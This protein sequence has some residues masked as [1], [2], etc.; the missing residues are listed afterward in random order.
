ME[1]G[2]KK[3][4]AVVTGVAGFI[5]SR[6]A[7]RL[8]SEGFVVVGVD[9]LSG[10]AISNIPDGVEFIVGDLTCGATISKLPRSPKVIMH[11]AGQSS[12]EISFDDPSSD[13]RKNVVST[14][15][16]IRYGLDEHV[17]KFIYAS[18]MSVYGD[19]HSGRVA[20][21]SVSVPISC[22]GVGKLASENYLR[23]YSSRL[24]FVCLRMFN[25]YGP[26]Q[27]LAN[28]RQGMVSIFVAQALESGHIQVKG[29]LDRFRDFVF[30]DDVVDAWV[31]GAFCPGVKNEIINVG[32]GIK[33]SVSELLS[34][35]NLFIP[36]MSYEVV[37]ETPGDQFGIYADMTKA[38]SLLNFSAHTR[39]SVGLEKFIASIDFG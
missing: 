4:I 1:L 23:I 21:N 17:E 31:R 29:S 16:L 19:Q 8:L 39:L 10:G 28:L 3:D 38:Q 11:L 20:E 5:G 30:I 12:G 37:C 27:D 7:E 33:T 26:G 15:N 18:S 13:L 34:A 6:L 32:T 2:L 36:N 24:P 14:L 35:I 22:Y 9:D 25:V